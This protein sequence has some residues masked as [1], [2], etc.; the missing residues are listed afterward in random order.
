MRRKTVD[1]ETLAAIADEIEAGVYDMK[2]AAEHYHIPLPTLYR[3]MK[4]IGRA[5]KSER[6]DLQ[7]RCLQEFCKA[8]G[9]S[10]DENLSSREKMN[11]MDRLADDF[12]NGILCKAFGIS[13]NSYRK[14]CAARGRGST[15][16]E[17]HEKEIEEAVRSLFQMTR[18]LFPDLPI[19]FTPIKLCRI[20][21]RG[22]FV[23][24]PQLVNRILKRIKP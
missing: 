16:H 19:G 23:T 10:L 7:M 4:S 1:D 2:G 14:H 8:K 11:L 18:N 12:P 20:L 21:R 3:R 13:P 6:D 22:G 5:T 15:V 9:I 17:R 24:S